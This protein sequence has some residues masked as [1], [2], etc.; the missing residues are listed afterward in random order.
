MF[1]PGAPAV[2]QRDLCG[3]CRYSRRAGQA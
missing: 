2:G 3:Q 1:L